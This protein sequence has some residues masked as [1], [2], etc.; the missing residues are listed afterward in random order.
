[1]ISK[2]SI[3][4]AKPLG[5]GKAAFLLVESPQFGGNGPSLTRF[6]LN[7]Q[8]L[9]KG[10]DVLTPTLKA[11]IPLCP[12]PELFMGSSPAQGLWGDSCMDAEN[13]HPVLNE[14]YFVFL[15]AIVL[16]LVWGIFF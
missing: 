8:S 1:M 9:Q 2:S 7:S 3:R 6:S 11:H 10:T 5:N 16:F 12:F 14:K 13:K 4:L 15:Q